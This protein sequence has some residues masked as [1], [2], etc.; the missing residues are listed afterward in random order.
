MLILSS[1]FRS[2]LNLIINFCTPLGSVRIASCLLCTHGTDLW[3]LG[4]PKGPGSGERSQP[5]LPSFQ[6]PVLLCLCALR[7][8]QH[9]NAWRKNFPPRG[10]LLC[11]QTRE[12]QENECL[13]WCG[14]WRLKAQPQV[15]VYLQLLAMEVRGRVGLWVST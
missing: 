13:I 11:A 2:P 5:A 9:C 12:L 10:L 15:F 4:S 7:L 6:A 1:S 14:P 3:V 8:L